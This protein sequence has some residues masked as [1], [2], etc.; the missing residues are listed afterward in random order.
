MEGRPSGRAKQLGLHSQQTNSQTLRVVMPTVCSRIHGQGMRVALILALLSARTDGAILTV[1]ENGDYLTPSRAALFA[2]DG[3]EVVVESGRY[4]G[5]VAVWTQ[6]NLTIRGLGPGA[7]IQSDGAAAEGKAL[8]V[9]KGDDVVIENIGFSGARVADRNGAGIRHEGSNL[10]VRNCR[11]HTNENGILS[12]RTG[13]TTRIELSVFADNGHGDGRSHS[14]YVGH[15]DHL[16]VRGNLF[17]RARVGHHIKS[18]ARVTEISYNKILDGES[19]DSSYLIDLAEGGDAVILGNILQQGKEAE[20]HTLLSYGA[21]N[22]RATG[23]RLVVM[24][25]T[26]VNEQ[27]GGFFLKIIPQQVNVHVQN[28]VFFGDASISNRKVHGI[29]NLVVSRAVEDQG[30]VFMDSESFNYLLSAESPAIDAGSDPRPLGLGAYIPK[31]E[32]NDV[33]TL[34][35]RHDDRR[36][37]IGAYEFVRSDR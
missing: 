23:G 6:S 33:A 4:V 18:R 17:S 14:L 20:N 7:D 34:I 36:I 15:A 1:G 26:F 3:D 31:L 19:G 12:G 37:D 8:W 9:V 5:D 35:P 2:Q 21:E 11:F 22:R 10:T 16:I 25:N 13:G 32:Y 27:T 29:T 28:N 30:R 24:N